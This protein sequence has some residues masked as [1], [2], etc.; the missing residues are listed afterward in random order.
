MEIFDSERSSQFLLND[1]FRR[2]KFLTQ[3]G[4]I[5]FYK[6]TF[7][8]VF[9]YWAPCYTNHSYPQKILA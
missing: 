9:P 6:M 4:R 2:Q 7:T 8:N 5:N 1:F 3:K